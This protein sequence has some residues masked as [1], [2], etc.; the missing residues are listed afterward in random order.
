[1][2][3]L[4]PVYSHSQN[5]P[6]VLGGTF[7]FHNITCQIQ[8]D[9]LSMI[10]RISIYIHLSLILEQH[11]LHDSQILLLFPPP[12]PPSPLSP[13]PSVANPAHHPTSHFP[14]AITDTLD[15]NKPM[16]KK[17][18]SLVPS[19]IRSFFSRG[20][21]IARTTTTMP[22]F[23][24]DLVLPTSP[25]RTPSSGL[26]TNTGAGP[27][28]L[29]RLS[30]I[31]GVGGRG[32]L[33]REKEHDTDLHGTPTSMPTSFS[34]TLSQIQSSSS[35]LS[36]SPGVVFPAPSL[37]VDLAEKERRDPQRRLKGDEKAGLK[38]LLGW[39]SSLH[40][41]EKE[42][43]RDNEKEKEKGRG[44]VGLQGFLRH[45]GFSVLVSKHVL[46]TESMEE[47]EREKDL[48]TSL[49]VHSAKPY[50]STICGRPK[51]RTLGYYG[52]G[53]R[54]DVGQ[55]KGVHED[56]D[57]DGDG[58]L[59]ERIREWMEGAERGC[60]TGGCTAKKGEHEL[61]YVHGGI[62]VAVNIGVDEGQVEMDAIAISMWESCLVCGAHTNRRIMSDG[63]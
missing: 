61:R 30:F 1:M 3:I 48:G 25:S 60:T 16:S 42:R 37:I 11:L 14:R 38:S 47:K 52:D 15:N 13:S 23:G 58:R 10:L 62:R 39:D 18:Q 53:R 28:R 12:N 59:G 22:V 27:A 63:S 44:M 29:G 43:E 46:R 54:D 20:G 7:T 19:S 21:G 31:G 26:S 34:S 24:S 55:E 36:T 4:I 56:K 8:H 5:L 45:Q 50:L 41:K 17:L 35:L 2:T 40:G 6:A 32:P 33:S 57:E 9:L 51:W 49:Y